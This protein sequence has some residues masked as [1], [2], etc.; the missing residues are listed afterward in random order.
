MKLSKKSGELHIQVRKIP[1]SR[2]EITF[3]DTGKTISKDI[4]NKIFEPFFTTRNNGTGLG[5]WIVADEIAKNN[6]TIQAF[7]ED[8]KKFIVILPQEKTDDE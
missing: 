3:S 1:D 5:L 2:L 7:G 8:N 6:G 4:V